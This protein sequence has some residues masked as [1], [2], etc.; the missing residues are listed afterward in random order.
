MTD[1]DIGNQISGTSGVLLGMIGLGSYL[2]SVYRIVSVLWD[3]VLKPNAN[4][5][6]DLFLGDVV[7]W[8]DQFQRSDAAH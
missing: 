2:S 8:Q 7:K 1:L 5:G 3:K 6:D 4:D